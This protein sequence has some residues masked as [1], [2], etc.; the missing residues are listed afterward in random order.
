MELNS[1]LI[2]L[3]YMIIGIFG[4]VFLFRYIKN[5]EL[6]LDQLIGVS[7]GLFLLAAAI[8]WRRLHQTSSSAN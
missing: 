5:G 6:L 2:R 7:V 1:Y 4:G 8:I 3:S